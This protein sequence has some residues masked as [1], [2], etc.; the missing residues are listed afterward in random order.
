MNA[1]LVDKLSN[2]QS[3]AAWALFKEVSENA[4]TTEQAMKVIADSVDIYK[5]HPEFLDMEKKLNEKMIPYFSEED[6]NYL[7]SF[8]KTKSAF[9]SD[10]KDGKAN[11]ESIK[12]FSDALNNVYKIRGE[13]LKK[14]PKLVEEN[15]HFFLLLE[16]MQVGLKKAHF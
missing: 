10:M 2:L 13:V 9:L 11:L 3:C 6:K 15:K 12:S 4:K 8:D 14:E 5:E 1:T 16:N 7:L